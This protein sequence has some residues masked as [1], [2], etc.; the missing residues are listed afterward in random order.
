M[1]NFNIR[2]YKNFGII[3]PVPDG[4]LATTLLKL[5]SYTRQGAEFMPNPEWAIIKLYSIKK[6][7]FPWGFKKLVDKVMKQWCSVPISN[8]SYVLDV[9]ER[10]KLLSIKTNALRP[11]QNDAVRALYDN[12]GGLLQ[13]PTGS[14][15][16]KTIIEWLKILDLPAT[17][18]VQTLDIK[19]QWNKQIIGTK[20]RCIN[21]QSKLVE[22]FVEESDVLVF[23][24]A[25]HVAAKTIYT[26]AMKAKSDTIIAGCSATT[27]RDD[28]EDM[29]IQAAIG[30]VVYS[31]SRR[32]LI[33]Q[34]FL[35]DA[36]VEYHTTSFDSSQDRVLNYAEIYKKHVVENVYR[37]AIIQNEVCV[38]ILKGK[39]ILILVS[40]IE[41]GQTIF[42]NLP[43]YYN[44]IFLN[45][46]SKK[47]IREQDL[48]QFDVIIATSIFDEGVDLPSLDVIILAAGGKSSVK[49]TQRVGRV[50]RPQEGKKAL[51][52]DFIDTPKYL[53]EHYK[54][55]RSILEVDFMVVE[56]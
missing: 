56:V 23:D 22:Q 25:H 8:D 11:Y 43:D 52:I 20:I 21:H 24:E 28:G 51:I 4:R 35:A 12:D 39:K 19:A 3:S 5:M 14:G 6:G 44:K 10:K 18:V 30:D 36:D 46:G 1:T 16:T 32:E 37:N 29:R 33:D 13:M 26:I 45:G 31:I 42:D 55:R 38:N 2:R 9:K 54:R 48:T 15:K 27:K 40:Q 49:L 7:T 47:E 34:G 53:I 50:L 41:H 17:V